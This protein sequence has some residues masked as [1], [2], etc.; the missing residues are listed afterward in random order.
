MVTVAHFLPLNGFDG[1]NIDYFY[2]TNPTEGNTVGVGNVERTT[3][4][5]EQKQF[6]S[7]I[8]LLMRFSGLVRPADH[9]R[10]LIVQS[11]TVLELYSW[12]IDFSRL[13]VHPN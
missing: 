11:G 7:E 3:N 6:R 12:E 10:V 1:Y 8:K 5:Y 9:N 4:N 2:S 13:A